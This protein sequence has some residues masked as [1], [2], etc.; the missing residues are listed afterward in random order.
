MA[1]PEVFSGW[2]QS[3]TANNVEIGDWLSDVS[4]EAEDDVQEFQ[5]SNGKPKARTPSGQ[6]LT[7][8]FTV[9]NHPTPMAVLEPAYYSTEDP[10]PTITFVLTEYPGRSIT[11][12]ATIS[13]LT[14]N[15]GSGDIK[16]VDVETLPQSFSGMAS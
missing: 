5:G 6:T 15:G 13:H 11:I 3:L 8:T 14:Y 12:L 2:R 16:T 10:K 7:F 1:A 4:Y 9:A